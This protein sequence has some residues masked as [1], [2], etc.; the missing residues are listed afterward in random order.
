MIRSVDGEALM[1]LGTRAKYPWV[2]VASAATLGAAL[3]LGTVEVGFVVI[4]LISMLLFIPLAPYQR[5]A[6]ALVAPW[7]VR[8]LTSVGLF[9][10]YMDFI[11]FPIV[12]LLLGVAVV[13]NALRTRLPLS[14]QDLTIAGPVALLVTALVSIGGGAGPIRSISGALL[15]YL[16]FLLLSAVLLDPIRDPTI[17]GRL[18][19]IV[20]TIV[21]IQVPISL[22]QRFT[23]GH[24]DA[25][26][27]TLVGADAGHHVMPSVLILGTL[28]LLSTSKSLRVRVLASVTTLGILII[29]D[30]KAPLF[31][32]P[33]AAGTYFFVDARYRRAFTRGRGRTSWFQAMAGALV[34]AAVI[35]LYPASQTA[36]GYVEEALARDRGKIRVVSAL[37]VDL[38]ERPSHL[39]AGL[40]AGHSVSRLSALVGPSAEAG[41]PASLLGLDASDTANR[42]TWIAT[43]GQDLGSTS[44]F[45]SPTSSWLGILGDYGVIGVLIFSS[46]LVLTFRRLY[47]SRSRLA[48][49]AMAGWALAQPL[50][51]AYDWFEQPAYMLMLAAVSGLALISPDT[52]PAG[53]RD[54]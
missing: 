53:R 46:L 7:I 21:A 39:L 45:H 51:L 12:G 37:W 19:P 4:A 40:G 41:S 42:Y 54:G 2:V 22:V 3:G 33:L 25:M 20:G 15:L 18:F 44:S 5:L 10:R 50:A 9:P 49:A 17:Q 43:L 27:G 8:P 32:L 23:E 28:V 38:S 34:L 6:I 36:V 48:P 1:G 47:A 52:A 24:S 31:A 26:K 30:A 13:G 14:G 29:A 35:G 11:E 16:P